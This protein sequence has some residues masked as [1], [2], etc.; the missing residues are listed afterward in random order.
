MSQR[1]IV[2]A[3]LIFAACAVGLIVTSSA[4]KRSFSE[5]GNL[6]EIVWAKKFASNAEDAYEKF[7]E[8]YADAAFSTQHK[9]AHIIGG[10]LY[11]SAGLPG[12]SIC[13]ESFAFGCY[14]GFFGRVI[15]DK[16]TGIIPD[17]AQNCRKRYGTHSTG[18]EHGI[19]HGIME[20]TG[21]ARL[22]DG[23][24]LCKATNQ[25]HEL[26]GC[27]SGLFMEYNSSMTFQNGNVYV[28]KRPIDMKDLLAPCDS[29]VPAPYRTS[30]YFEIPLWWKAQFDTDDEKIGNLC[31]GAQTQAERNA[32]YRGWGTAVAEN[33][34]HNPAL[35]KKTCGLIRDSSG[36][37]VC[38]L[39]VA[40][41]FFPAG[42][43]QAAQEMCDGLSGSLA[44]ECSSL[45]PA[46][47][48]L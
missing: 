29:M 5:E 47:T 20:Y 48:S 38:A 28:D 35:A 9:N 27:T 4:G 32:C 17:L 46:G 8:T 31:A 37:D 42:Y 16:G 1:I 41:R 2:G 34:D 45:S 18:C 43:S 30:C 15:A 25:T 44:Q 11:N 26:Y 33:A 3:C 12:I 40:S 13:D 22:L 14:H 24:E 39:G 21:R 7:K 36:R 23:L 19:G 6:N 10:L